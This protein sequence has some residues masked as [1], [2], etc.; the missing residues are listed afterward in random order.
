LQKYRSP[1]SKDDPRYLRS[2]DE[3]EEAIKAMK[4]DDIKGFYKSFYGASNGYI[5]V[6]GD[7]DSTAVKSVITTELAGWKSPQPFSRLVAQT[8]TVVPINKNIETPDKANAIF[9]VAETVKLS[10]KDADYPAMMLANYM[11][12]GGGGLNSRLATRIRQKEGISYGVGS[13]FSAGYFEQNSGTFFAYAIYAPENVKRLD[14][15]FQQEIEKV[16][17]N[18]FTEQELADA[19]KGYLQSRRV[20]LAQDGSLAYTLNDYSYYGEKIAFWQKFDDD[21]SKLTLQ[22]V[23]AVVSKYLNYNDMSIVKAGD[24]NKKPAAPVAS[25]K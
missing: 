25:G 9:Y 19:K 22:Q 15:A 16:T 10:I 4:P 11:I 23:N 2:I 17:K 3:N 14:T 1:Y 24:F 13:Y 6:V 7:F 21:I 12:G 8:K 18:G 20:E 5:T